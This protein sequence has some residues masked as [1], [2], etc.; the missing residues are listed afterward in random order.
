MKPIKV[1]SAIILPLKE[2]FSYK[3]FG[4]VSVWVND[5]ISQSKKNNDLI[6]CRNISNNQT[7]LR[8]NVNPIYTFG[9]MH[10]N[11]I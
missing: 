7:Y 11:P 6:F 3:N 10:P 1:K 8:K 2:N 9:R 4:A 5:Y